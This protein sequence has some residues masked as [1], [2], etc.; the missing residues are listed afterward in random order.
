MALAL[1]LS[2]LALAAVLAAAGIAKL[3]DRTG[4]RDALAG[5]GLPRRWIDPVATALPVA[6]LAVALALL[7]RRSAWWGALAALVLLAVFTAVVG[8]ALARGERPDCRCFGQL[9]PSPI[10]GGT[11]A[12]NGALIALALFV[13]VAG[14]GDPGRSALAWL[15]ELDSASR[16]LA[17]IG[18][19]A[20]GL[21]VAL[22]VMGARLLRGQGEI[23]T[24]LAALE[25]QVDAGRAG[26]Q[27]REDA[28]PPDKGLPVGAQ[29]PPFAL[30]DLDGQ[31]R[32]LAALLQQ[33]RPVLLL[34]VG[35]ACDPCLALV[36]EIGRWQREHAATLTLA[37]V[38]SGPAAENRAKFGDLD[39]ARL[40]LQADSEVADAYAAQWT[41]GALV[42]RRNGRLA[43]AVAYGDAAVR[44]LV[45][46]AA[47]AGDAPLVTPGE[48]RP[49][50]GLALV[51]RGPP[52]PGQPA[53]SLARPDLEGREIDLADYR[54][55]D[56]LVVFWQ[57]QCPHCQKLAEDLR[58]WEAEP[59]RGAPRLLVVSSGSIEENRAL[60]L[61][62]TIVLDEGF[63]IGKAFGARGTPSA[64]LVD[65][66]GR[67]ASTVGVGA[68]D[69][70]A[71][72]GVIPAV[73][74]AD[75]ESRPA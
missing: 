45:A 73:G 34:F 13:L 14:H 67:I 39:P 27:P 7:P 44:A 61:R 38:S 36:P 63:T 22:A 43:S 12:R 75:T 69:V 72:A 35:P 50:G 56:T 26:A 2:R 60:E 74:A 58:R 20:V 46:R 15:L 66:E 16:A 40:L 42:I 64:V 71:L 33:G 55:R 10:G 6:E 32:S 23:L 51:H 11:L 57:P 18:L 59:P 65:G 47:I 1:F 48:S 41:P 9:A 37:L 29:A 17:S 21:L 53:P 62:S 52:G 19:V 24:R 3:V 25:D 8:R 49:A 28:L 70:L 4:S 54:G 68:R 31:R 5:F 30:P